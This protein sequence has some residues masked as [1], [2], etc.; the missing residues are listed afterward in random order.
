MVD[1]LSSR[2]ANSIEY[3]GTGI[4]KP[5]S[6]PL[7]KDDRERAFASR[8]IENGPGTEIA[9]NRRDFL[10]STATIPCAF[11]QTAQ[12]VTH[13][14]TVRDGA[15]LKSSVVKGQDLPAVG[16]SPGARA[17]VHF[18]G[19]TSQLAAVAS[20]VVTLEPG[21]RPH[22]PHRHPEEELVIVTEGTGEIEIDGVP[23]QVKAGDMMYAE[24]N[25]LHGITNTGSTMMTFYFT[26]MLGKNAG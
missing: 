26:K 1:I 14:D 23:T 17:K 24:A 13:V 9:M 21:S 7:S 25:V 11:L 22:P 4:Q 20:G 19:P 18:N 2:N 16:D 8:M 3:E 12:H 15:P 10:A 5:S 6:H